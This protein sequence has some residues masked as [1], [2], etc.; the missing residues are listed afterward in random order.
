M[1]LFATNMII[2]TDNP[3]LIFIKAQRCKAILAVD[4]YVEDHGPTL[5]EVDLVVVEL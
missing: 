3:D 5:L 2:E 1:N 4:Q